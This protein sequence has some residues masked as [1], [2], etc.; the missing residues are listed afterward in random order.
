MKP[1]IL[2]TS[3]PYPK[4]SGKVRDVYDLGDKLLIIATDRISAYDVVMPDGIPAKG[5]ILTALSVFWFRKFPSFEN[6]L[7]STRPEVDKKYEEQVQGRSMLVKKAN[8][9][10][11]E[12]VARGYLAGS[13][14]K[15][16][17]KS[18][19]V[20]GIRLPPGLIQCDKLPEPIFTPATKEESGHDI[21]IS[22]EEMTERVGRELAV[23]LKKR[24]LSLYSRAADYAASRGVIIADTKFEFGKLPDGKLILIDEVLTPDSS[25]FW[26]ME[27][28]KPGLDQPSFDKQYL[29]NWLEKQAWDKTPPAPRLPPDLIDGT[30]ER[31]LDAYRLL[32]GSGFGEME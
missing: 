5:K 16:Y 1:A 26:P 32:T 23:E 24:T 25:R 17:Q 8:V 14:W 13:G 30:R 4:R 22:F 20:C 11:I 18:Q 12:C 2:E 28:Y 3:L 19:T 6:H 29:R 15:E 7:I 9:V 10:S 27:D 31:Y 21:N